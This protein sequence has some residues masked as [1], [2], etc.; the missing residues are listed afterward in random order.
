MVS[1]PVVRHFKSSKL[2]LLDE[3][4]VLTCGVAVLVNQQC[5]AGDAA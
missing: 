5:V 1:L 3:F 4:G 2:F